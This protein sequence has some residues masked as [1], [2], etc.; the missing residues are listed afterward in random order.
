MIRG[1]L[2]LKLLPGKTANKL[3]VGK[4]EIVEIMRNKRRGEKN[5]F[6][7]WLQ[8]DLTGSQKKLE[9]LTSTG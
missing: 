5:I 3:H 9:K 8:R 4:N 2:S 1:K 6:K 7:L